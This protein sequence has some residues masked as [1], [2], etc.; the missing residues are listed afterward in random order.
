MRKTL[1]YVAPI[2]IFLIALELFLRLSQG[3]LFP[4]YNYKYVNNNSGW[5]QTWE[6]NSTIQYSTEEF[7]FKNTFNELGHREKSF[8]TFKESNMAFKVLCLGDSFTEGDGASYENSWVRHYENF[9][10]RDTSLAVYNAG[11]CGSDVFFDYMMLKEKL[12]ASSP[13]LVIHCINNSDIPD[14]HYF[15]GMER[16]N[17]DGTG[18]SPNFKKWEVLYANCHIFRVGVRIFTSYDENL[19]KQNTWKE[20]EVKAYIKIA[21]QLSSIQAFCEKNDIQY[22][23]VLMPSPYEV[24]SPENA[25]FERLFDYVSENTVLISIFREMQESKMSENMEYYVWP[26]NGHYNANGYK[27]MGEIIYDKIKSYND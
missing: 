5:F 8:K 23:A 1:K 4:D 21:N 3:S 9:M 11:V 20:D 15:G 18:G 25:E 26:E 12:I 22:I 27:I 7:S 14:V 10:R 19:I 24:E 17:E 2:F 13:N 16:F 6:P